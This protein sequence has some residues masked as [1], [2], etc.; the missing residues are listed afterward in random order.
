ML[1][2]RTVSENERG[3]KIWKNREIG[4]PLKHAHS[5][6]RFPLKVKMCSVR[7]PRVSE[8]QK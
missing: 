2:V 8:V 5:N 6:T 4:F 3:G 1:D 7:V